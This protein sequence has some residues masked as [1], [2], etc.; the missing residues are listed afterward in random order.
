LD[1]GPEHISL[2]ELAETGNGIILAVGPL[3]F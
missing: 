2:S 1:R 3:S